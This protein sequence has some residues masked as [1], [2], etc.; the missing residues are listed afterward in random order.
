MAIT[1]VNPNVADNTGAGTPAAPKKLIPTTLAPGDRVRILRGTTYT[2][3]EWTTVAGTAVQHIVFEAYANADGSD[4]PA[5]PRPIINRTTVVSTYASANKDYVDVYDLDVR[6][7]V[8]VANDAAMF[9]AGQDATFRNV[10][11]DTNVGAFS[12]WNKS[13][14]TVEGCEFIGVSHSSA[15]NNN[16]VTISAD[17]THIDGI[18]LL[19]NTLSHKGGGGTNSHVVRAETSGVAYNLTNLVID[20]CIAPPA[21]NGRNP[22]TATIGLRLARCPGVKVRR[23]QVRGVLAG[24]FVNGAGA[25]ITGGEILDNDFSDC[26]HFGVHL[27]GATRGFKIGRNLCNNAGSNMGPSYYG[28]GI[29]I[30]SSGGQGQ[31]GGHEIFK[32]VAMYARNWGGPQD[33]GSEGCGIGLD[34]GTDECY[35]WGNYMAQNEGNGLQ[36]YGGTGTDTGGHRI[37]GNYFE[38][39]CTASF[40]NRRTGGTALTAFVA[41]CAFAVHKGRRSLL[42]NNLFKNA[43]CGVSESSG[44]DNIL[45][46]ANNIFVDVQYPYMLP[47][48]FGNVYNNIFHSPTV[49]VQIYSG[50][51]TDANG[52]PTFPG[53]GFT[54]VNDFITDPMLDENNKPRAGSPAIAAGRAM[55]TYL[56]YA[57]EPFR[58]SPAIGMYES[59]EEPG[60]IGG[61]PIVDDEYGDAASILV[62]VD[63][64]GTAGILQSVMAGGV[65][66]IEDGNPLWNVGATYAAGQ[67]VYMANVHRVYESIKDGNTGKIPTDPVNQ[68]NAAGVGTWWL[69]IGPTNKYAMFDGLV[70]SQTV[71]ASPAV[72]TMTPGQFNGFALMGIDADTYAVQVLDAPGGT[73]VYNEPT[74][75]LEGS[76]VADYY[77]YFFSPFKPVTQL[78]RTGIDPYGTA[79][80]KLTLSKANGPVKLGM[81]AIGD[82]RPSGIPQRDATV[83][84]Q[85]FSVVKQ[86]AFGNTKVIKRTNATGLTINTKMEKEDAATVLAS[87]KEVLGVPVVVVGSQAQFY[88]WMTVF[89][90]ISARMSP[91][92]FPYVTLN[93][94]VRGLV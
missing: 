24:V 22:N 68:F 60:V 44:N 56:D 5:L 28:R 23:N 2:G 72:I 47:A 62:P 84:P 94:T 71:M 4:N 31:N 80:I 3:N 77:E 69:D 16:L 36:Q 18:R 70:S 55:G 93:L 6:G 87:I 54:G 52:S 15:N 86:D 30:S 14:I 9:Y 40:K 8:A 20:D 85:D 38:N 91:A 7:T 1:Y 46:K 43:R 59:Y 76:Q 64:F 12:A 49:A 10:R 66:M 21:V 74:T 92:E 37:V 29:E 73:L 79:Q 57:G 35:V 78:V 42:A 34:D 39:N 65:E 33:N 17:N 75:S 90:L 67:R 25:I 81:F 89:G 41:D 27:P 88:E 61:A 50:T 63:V 11:V 13:N 19:R 45:D 58:S 82:M 32:N 83:E 51:T 48:G 26:Y 53:L